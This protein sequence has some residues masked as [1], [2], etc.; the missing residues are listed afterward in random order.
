ML[1]GTFGLISPKDG[2]S[3]QGQCGCCTVIVDD[4]AVVSCT[5]PATSVA[6]SSVLTIEGFDE[7]ERSIFADSFVACGGLQCGFCTPGIVAR[8]KALLAA[9][10]C[11][12]DDRIKRALNSHHCRCTGYR[13]IVDSIKMAAAGLRGERLPA[14]D[15]TGHIGTSTSRLDARALAL[16]DKRFVDDIEF[17]GMLHGAVLLSAHPRA[18]IKRI[19]IS[20][21]SAFRGVVAVVTGKD[22]PGQ[23]FLRTHRK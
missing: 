10:P 23:R 12:S 20:R 3:P 4:R 18:L 16:G 22:T 2:C 21:A 13:S 19:D 14:S 5:L 17:D 9:D 11:P 6:G 8:A 1:R 7:Q 15:K